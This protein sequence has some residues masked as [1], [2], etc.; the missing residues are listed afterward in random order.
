MNKI[1]DWTGKDIQCTYSKRGVLVLSNPL[2]NLIST[3]LAV[4]PT[5]EIL[6]KLYKSKHS[7]SIKNIDFDISQKGIGYYSDLQSINSEDAITWSIFGTVSRSSQKIKSKWIQELF[8]NI[9][10]PDKDFNSSEIYLWRRI[11]HPDTL[12]S[13]GPEIDIGIL[14]PNSVVFCEAK[15][16]SA[17]AKNQGKS[18]NKNQI[19]LRKEFLE[20]YGKLIFKNN[21]NFIT[22]TISLSK[23][24]QNDLNN[25]KSITWEEISKFKYHP[26]AN[27]VK[28]YYQWKFEYSINKQGA[29]Q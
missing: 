13:G 7:S 25:H 5:P 26:L 3:G 8:Q 2:E 15:W 18:K 11:P 19:E 28:N 22:L 10:I 14:T 12:V 1:K 21:K 20:K 6:Q 17:I 27:E 23:D 16:K 4:W 9:K 29:K 24:I